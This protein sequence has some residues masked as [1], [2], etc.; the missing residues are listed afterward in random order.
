MAGLER[1]TV[2]SLLSRCQTSRSSLSL[3]GP[4]RGHGVF[5]CP[6]GAGL[7]KWFQHLPGTFP[8]RT[9]WAAKDGRRQQVLLR[10]VPFSPLS[11][12]GDPVPP[13]QQTLHP[14]GL[15]SLPGAAS[16]E[17]QPGDRVVQGLSP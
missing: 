4:S 9:G 12:S 13:A 1:T 14:Q 11:W 2:H 10:R 17:G 3:P 15:A 8:S 16:L 6:V 7:P 5:T